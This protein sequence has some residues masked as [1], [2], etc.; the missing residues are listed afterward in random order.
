MRGGRCPSGSSTTRP[1]PSTTRSCTSPP[2]P[3]T[4]R[5]PSPA[6]RPRATAP[7][8]ARFRGTRHPHPRLAPVKSIERRAREN[9]TGITGSARWRARPGQELHVLGAPSAWSFIATLGVLLGLALAWTLL[10]LSGV[11]FSVF[12]ATFI[13]LGLDPLVR[14]FQRRGM[15]RGVAILTVIILFIL[16]IAGMLWIVLPL[17]ITQA[18]TL[19]ESLPQ[20]YANLQQQQWFQDAS[21][22]SGGVLTTGY[23]RSWPPPSATQHV[24]DHRRRRTQRG[25]RDRGRDLDPGSSSSSSRSTSSPRSTRRR[26]RSTHSSRRRT[27]S[28]WSATPSASCRTSGRYLS[29]M[30]IL[31][32]STPPSASSSCSSR[33]CRSPS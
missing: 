14:W 27:A 7:V 10:S 23:K 15:K 18:V 32:F 33:R 25:P 16:V 24:G 26:P 1:S 22:G 9:A 17:V 4:E 8:R 5:P 29:G 19:V 12:A 13:T 3:S 28:G 31:A 30:V 11:L 2:A 20:M 6:R 21:S